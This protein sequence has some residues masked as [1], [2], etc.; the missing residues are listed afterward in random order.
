MRSGLLVAA[1]VLASASVLAV[2]QEPKKSDND[3]KTITVTG[4][5]EGS[6]LSVHESDRV[7]SFVERYRLRGSKQLMKEMI[8]QHD[9]HM[10]EVSGR[11]TDVSG[12][13]HAG[14]TTNIGAKTKVYVGAKEVPVVPTAETP[15]LD[16]TS[17]T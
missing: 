12:T 2:S 9:K 8:S 3:N 10:L 1:V 7:G 5:L 16:V 13:E 6:Y 4:C 17:Y 14:H 11:V 15:T